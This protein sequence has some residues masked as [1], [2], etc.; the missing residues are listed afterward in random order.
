[1]CAGIPLALQESGLLTGLLLLVVVAFVTDY[2]VL[3][4]IK[5]GILA[6]K[7]SYQVQTGAMSCSVH[8]SYIHIIIL[9]CPLPHLS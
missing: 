9:V 2:T 5:D 8:W 1:M 3:L 6:G 4:L 7:S